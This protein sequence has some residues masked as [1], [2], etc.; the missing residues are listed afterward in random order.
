M[1]YLEHKRNVL[2]YLM[3]TLR[4]DASR[5]Q[6]A[7]ELLH[8]YQVAY[9][10][11][12]LLDAAEYLVHGRLENTNGLWKAVPLDNMIRVGLCME[13]YEQ[14][15]KGGLKDSWKYVLASINKPSRLQILWERA[16]ELRRPYLLTKAFPVIERLKASK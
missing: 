3:D 7:S 4:L 8:R 14:D 16:S 6:L 5:L 11:K 13:V 12:K 10:P 2:V 15:E 9:P 1:E